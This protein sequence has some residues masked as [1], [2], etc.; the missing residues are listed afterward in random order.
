MNYPEWSNLKKVIDKDNSFFEY[1][2]YPTGEMFY[3]E[4]SFY[5]QLNNFKELYSIE[6]YKMILQKMEQLVKEKKKIIFT[7]DFENPFI[8][9]DGFIY[10]EFADITDFLKIKI[11][12]KSRGS[13]Y[14][15]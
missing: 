1:Y 14:G 12:D 11:E 13:D 3:V 6:Q 5:T 8:S 7:Y 4:P 2:I 10:L 15:D 9:K